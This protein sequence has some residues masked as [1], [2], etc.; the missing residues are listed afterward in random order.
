MILQ[1]KIGAVCKTIE[2]FLA[3]RKI[4]FKVDRALR[5]VGQITRRYL[6]LV[7]MTRI[8]ANILH[9]GMHFSAE[10]FK[11]F[12]PVAWLHK[13]FDLHLFK[14]AGTKKEISWSDLITKRLP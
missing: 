1:I 3:K 10:I 8:K 9:P 7:H 12:F 5:I 2:L 4:K 11:G 14:L 13:I 6:E